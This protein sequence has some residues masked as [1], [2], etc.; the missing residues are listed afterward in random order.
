MIGSST[1]CLSDKSLLGSM[2]RASRPASRARNNAAAHRRTGAFNAY[3]G[4]CA[5]QTWRDTDEGAAAHS[6]E[7][8]AGTML[9]PWIEASGRS[10]LLVSGPVR[11]GKTA[12]VVEACAE[13]CLRRQVP[14]II[15]PRSTRLVEHRLDL[16]TRLGAP[17]FVDGASAVAMRVLHCEIGALYARAVPATQSALALPSASERV[18][19]LRELLPRL[20]LDRFRPAADP[21]RYLESLADYFNA[22]VKA[23]VSPEAYTQWTTRG[24]DVAAAPPPGEG[25]KELLGRAEHDELAAAYEAWWA[26]KRDSGELDADDAVHLA[27]QALRAALAA[28]QADVCAA[29][30]QQTVD[31][32]AVDDAQD[33][34]PAQARLVSAL[35]GAC[36]KAL[37][38]GDWTGTLDHFRGASQD[39]LAAFKRELQQPVAELALAA[40]EPLPPP[41]LV[42]AASEADVIAEWAA[43]Q[44]GPVVVAAR[45]RHDCAALQV[46]LALRGAHC[47]PGR[48]AL[49]ASDEARTLLSL[50][51]AALAA[52][53]DCDR[54]LLALASARLLPAY[55]ADNL[56]T[57]R[58]GANRSHATVHALLREGGE[59]ARKLL[60]DVAALG[61]L[62]G[63]GAGLADLVQR[64]CEL[65]GLDA[66]ADAG[67]ER[68]L[69]RVVDALA[70]AAEAVAPG[71][72]ASAD[73]AMVLARVDRLAALGGPADES[74][75]PAD[76]EVRVL[77]LHALVAAHDPGSLGALVI[78]RCADGRLPS[79]RR[80]AAALPVPRSLVGAPR[81]ADGV[82]AE[83]PFAAAPHN[84]AAHVAAERALLDCALARAAGPCLVTKALNDKPSRFFEGMEWASLVR[85]DAAAVAEQAVQVEEAPPLEALVDMSHSRLADYEACP[86]RFFG[87]RVARVPATPPLVLGSALHVAVERV[88]LDGDA[89][90][91]FTE[92]WADE[93]NAQP[94]P[95]GFMSRE[96]VDALR[97]H[98]LKVATQFAARPRPFPVV[99]VEHRFQ[100]EWRGASVVGV[101]DL[102]EKL[103]S[104]GTCL[105]DFKSNTTDS[106]KLKRK[107]KDN[108]QLALYAWAYQVQT[109]SLPELVAIESIETGARVAETPSPALIEKVQA[110][111]SAAMAGIRAQRFDP[112]PSP[113]TC[114]QCPLKRTCYY[115]AA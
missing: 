14:V 79:S 92:A 58:Q 115:S 93:M 19:Q 64:A 53:G 10:A 3:R 78:A 49:L 104:G 36:R 33:F 25:G 51:R 77:T 22:L 83:G 46:A 91:A 50:L 17:A 15:V 67:A 54:E 90:S 29:V 109:G 40:P 98:G 2:A 41:L 65:S 97:T 95:E 81:E 12:L 114:S 86:L 66:L 9:R 18:L 73:A 63:Q 71:A 31:A 43:A 74:D 52:E 7:L 21:T 101:I 20:P 59:G 4:V 100:F 13:V 110:R 112:T 69:S 61:A 70:R 8:R 88:C 39:N 103:P 113:L 42:E 6:S 111:L 72:A 37:V 38:C 68:R 55:R 108:V 16:A 24:S 45:S 80:A 56:A 105:V 35:A 32:V 5:L 87:R 1:I 30:W 89:A 44:H 76:G 82:S 28:G 57:L 84:R 107:A 60:A 62:A 99:Q 94:P 47:R 96:H 106:V 85:R 11:S 48:G 23:D 102:V 26:R 75:E 27:G 34:T